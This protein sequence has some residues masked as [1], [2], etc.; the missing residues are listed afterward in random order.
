MAGQVHYS[1]TKMVNESFGLVP[2]VAVMVLGSYLDLQP[3]KSTIG[4]R[5]FPRFPRKEKGMWK[6]RSLEKTLFVIAASVAIAALVEVFTK[7]FFLASLIFL[8]VFIFWEAFETFL[9]R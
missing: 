9:N 1:H 4:K 7:D 8:F 2:L 3:L 6:K 5:S